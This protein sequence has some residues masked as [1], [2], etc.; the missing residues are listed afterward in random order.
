MPC[1]VKAGVRV[2][3]TIVEVNGVVVPE[4]ADAG[5][6]IPSGFARMRFKVTR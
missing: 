5:T 1:L 2:G 3:D 6:F 4:T